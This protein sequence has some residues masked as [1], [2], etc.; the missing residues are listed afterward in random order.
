MAG[1]N[2]LMVMM[3]EERELQELQLCLSCEEGEAAKR[4]FEF[5]GQRGT[6]RENES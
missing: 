2:E 5:S 6:R 3:K 1:L 4:G